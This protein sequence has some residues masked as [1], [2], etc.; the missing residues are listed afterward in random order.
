MTANRLM[1]LLA[2][3]ALLVAACSPKSRLKLGKTFEGEVVEAEGLVPLQKNDLPATEAAALAAAQ[4]SA[5]EK[6]VGVYISGATRVETAALVES[7]ILARTEGYISKYDILSKGPDGDFYRTRIRALVLFKKI[8]DDLKAAGLLDVTEV[9][10]PRVAVL[11]EET[12]DGQPADSLD[13][14][15]AM[16]QALLTRG[17]TVVDRSAMAG[18]VTQGILDAVN[19]A[20]YRKVAD[21][22]S[23]IGAEVVIT[24]AVSASEI[25]DQ[26]GRLGGLVSYRSRAAVQAVRAGTGQVLAT[27][28][29]DASG[30]DA[31]K[32]MAAA[33]AL[34]AAAGLAGEELSGTMYSI[35]QTSAET[36]VFLRGVKDLGKLQKFQEELR[37][38]AGHVKVLLRRFSDKTAEISVVGANKSAGEIAAVIA[39]MKSVSAEVDT[40]SQS[41]VEATLKD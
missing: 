27:A 29:R 11:L 2:V 26:D 4:R 22:G 1:S 17:Y 38:L 25:K 31:T 21:L 28:S 19:K 14:A 15:R 9:G 10:N 8:S 13:A 36:V 41:R 20:D 12:I 6:V 5:V 34:G 37:S 32:G 39:R 33:K 24:G 35:L 40:Y 3:S 16:S 18:A 7:K 23:S 30:L